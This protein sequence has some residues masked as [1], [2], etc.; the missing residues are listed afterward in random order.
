MERVIV[1]SATPYMYVSGLYN[2]VEVTHEVTKYSDL[3]KINFIA[4]TQYSINFIPQR[5]LF[6][7]L[8][9]YFNCNYSL[10]FPHRHKLLETYQSIYY[11]IFS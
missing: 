9:I 6:G 2:I 10:F 3:E 8:Q 1:E 4:H 11:N 7:N 5:S